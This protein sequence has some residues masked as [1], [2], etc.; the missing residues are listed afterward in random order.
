MPS[1]GDRVSW[2]GMSQ[3]HEVIAQM[4]NELK[5]PG[6]AAGWIDPQSHWCLSMQAVEIHE[7]QPRAGAW[8]QL[9]GDQLNF[10]YR[11]EEPP[12]QCLPEQVAAMPKDLDVA[13][14]EPCRHV[15]L[16]IGGWQE[17]QL[18]A[19]IQGLLLEYYETSPP[20]Q[21]R[22]SLANLDPEAVRQAAA[23][24]GNQSDSVSSTGPGEPG[25]GAGPG[26]TGA[27]AGTERGQ[28]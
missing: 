8:I 12:Q 27:G 20:F 10:E 11:D 25:A 28:S 3:S 18:P 24:A 2:A 26:D 22:V 1:G 7:G 17:E 16:N 13:A 15:V 23:K 21:L 14:Y 6:R 4:L 19:V 5:K 9:K